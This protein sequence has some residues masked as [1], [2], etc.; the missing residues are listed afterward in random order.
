[1][2]RI[3]IP[4]LA[5]RHFARGSPQPLVHCFNDRMLK[6]DLKIHTMKRFRLKSVSDMFLVLSALTAN[7]CQRN[8][9]LLYS[10]DG[11]KH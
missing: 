4:L 1:M 6:Q 7:Q 2:N 5:S 10:I 8:G 11:S 3:G 9:I